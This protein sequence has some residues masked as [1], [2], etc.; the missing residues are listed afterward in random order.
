MKML[1]V[2]AFTIGCVVPTDG[3]IDTITK[4]KQ[5]DSLEYMSSPG[6]V[7][8]IPDSVEHLKKYILL[9]DSGDKIVD[10]LYF[11][12]E[13]RVVKFKHIHPTIRAYYPDY[14]TIIFDGYPLK[15]GEYKVIVNHSIYFLDNI[16]GYTYFEPWEIHIKRALLTTTELNPLRKKPSDCGMVIP[17]LKYS[18]LSFI[19]DDVKGDWAH[20]N[21]F[22]DYATQVPL[23][24]G[25]LKWRDG[26]KLLVT[27]Y[28]N[29]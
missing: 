9:R 3:I 18:D 27:L 28:Y 17:G 10:T 23:A 24:S 14:S 21:G 12:K 19:V 6:V 20:V 15:D 5:S 22:I 8:I 1:F 11:D 29:W 25:W 26:N 4:H 7:I 16:H 2:I 13:E